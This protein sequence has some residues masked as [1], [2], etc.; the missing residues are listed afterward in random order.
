MIIIGITG[1]FGT[2]KSFVA[3]IFK[4]LGAE[5]IDADKIAHEILGKDRTVYKKVVAVFGR[6]ILDAGGSIDRK[7]L[8]K[9][10]FDDK[11][12]LARLNS[13]IHPVVIRRIENEIK[14]SKKDILAV[15]APLIC[16]TSL[17]RL[18]DVLVVVKVSAP[19][20]IDRCVK[21]FKLDRKDVYKRIMCQMPLKTKIKKADYVI[22]NNGTRKRTERQVIKIWQELKSI[23]GLYPEQGNRW[24]AGRVEG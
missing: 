9:A 17:S 5:V 4:K 22:D 24:S 13:I 1:G 15:D 6:L 10:V 20:Q 7:A 14:V 23:E 12:R 19:R 2:G 3:G 18:I 11:K 21:K 8:G 16:E